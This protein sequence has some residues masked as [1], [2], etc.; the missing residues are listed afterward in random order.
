MYTDNGAVYTCTEINQICARIGTLLCHAP[1]RDGAAKGKIERF[2]RTCR[3][4]FLLQDLDLSSVE[5]LNEQF[6]Q[7][8]EQ[9]YN[10]ARHSVLQMKPI[11]RFGLDLRRIRFLD[12][13]DANDE[14]FFFEQDRHV[15]KDNTFSVAGVRFE[16]PRHLPNRTVQVRYNRASPQRVV[17]FFQGQR[18]GVASVLN[19]TDN[20]R[21]PARDSE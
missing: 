4:Q 14:L 19:P 20:D 16:A 12:P 15:R 21:A 10:R 6:A 18:M 9:H 7:W 8:L 1:V 5:R 2:F 3:D 17:V 11:D 13:M